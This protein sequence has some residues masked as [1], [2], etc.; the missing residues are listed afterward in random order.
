LT[1]YQALSGQSPQQIETRFAG[2]GYGELKREVADL[3]IMAFGPIQERYYT[4]MEDWAAVDAFL[5][6]GADTARCR[7]V[8][9]L[10]TVQERVGLVSLPTRESRLV[11][12]LFLL[13]ARIAVEY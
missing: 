8:V 6:K 13:Q 11:G 1:I 4:L 12:V 9:T 10:R 7:A 2:K 5:Q 3:I